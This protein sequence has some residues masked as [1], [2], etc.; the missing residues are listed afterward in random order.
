M[1][2]LREAKTV[3]LWSGG[4]AVAPPGIR[5]EDAMDGEAFRE[6]EADV[7]GAHRKDAFFVAADL[8]RDSCVMSSSGG[9]FSR[10]SLCPF[11]ISST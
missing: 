6:C 3:K 9:A 8:Y 10:Q 4:E 1:D 7:V 5:R 11:V 2:A